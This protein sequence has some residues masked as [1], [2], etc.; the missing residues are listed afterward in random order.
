MVDQWKS[1][2]EDGTLDKTTFMTWCPLP[3]TLPNRA[4]FTSYA[5][6]LGNYV[7]AHGAYTRNSTE[8]GIGGVNIRLDTTTISWQKGRI[9]GHGTMLIVCY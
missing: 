7:Y 4:V 9:S 5:S 8:V 1:S 3:I 2:T 6:T